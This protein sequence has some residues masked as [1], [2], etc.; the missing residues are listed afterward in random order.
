MRFN[1]RDGQGMFAEVEVSLA[2]IAKEIG[3]D[4]CST[5]TTLLP[6]P[7]WAHD[8]TECPECKAYPFWFNHITGE[9]V[10]VK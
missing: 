4:I 10:P 8:S 6:L 5:C 9:N 7:K 2:E 3:C 1:N